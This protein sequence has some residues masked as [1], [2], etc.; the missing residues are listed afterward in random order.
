MA[1]CDP[2]KGM[3]GVAGGP[4]GRSQCASCRPCNHE[5]G[6]CRADNLHLPESRPQHGLARSQQSKTFFNVHYMNI[7]HL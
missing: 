6:V 4:P 1:P 7:P 5:M 2:F 3:L